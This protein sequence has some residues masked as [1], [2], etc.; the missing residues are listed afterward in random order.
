MEDKVKIF[1]EELPDILTTDELITLI[2]N[3]I[4]SIK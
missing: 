3:L 4:K 2:T 1:V